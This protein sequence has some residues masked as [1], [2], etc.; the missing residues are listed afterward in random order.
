MSFGLFKRK[1]RAPAEHEWGGPLDL[2]PGDRVTYYQQELTLAGVVFLAE[3][4]N[5]HCQYH[6]LD[7]EERHVVIAFSSGPDPVISIEHP[8]PEEGHP[9]IEAEVFK[10]EDTTFKRG[11]ETA[12]TAFSF[13]GIPTEKGDE[14]KVTAYEDED[15]LA[16]LRVED[17]DG[18]VEVRAGDF[19]H[20]NE[21]V[22][23]R[24][25]DEDEWDIKPPPRIDLRSLNEARRAKQMARKKVVEEKKKSD[26]DAAREKLAAFEGE[27]EIPE[28]PE[29]VV[30]LSDIVDPSYRFT[31][32]ARLETSAAPEPAESR[33]SLEDLDAPIPAPTPSGS[34]PAFPFEDDG[35]D[36]FEQE[37]GA[38]ETFDPAP[39]PYMEYVENEREEEFAEVFTDVGLPPLEP[40][41]LNSQ[42]DSV[43][44][45]LTEESTDE[46]INAGVEE[47]DEFDQ[48]P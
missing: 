40:N 9:S 33:E 32:E 43:K 17:W 48:E 41:P 10:H 44:N 23:H 26:L 42:K 16:V 46:F 13:G 29:D 4:K 21:L 14:V 38:D 5:R 15:E 36:P 8:I 7:Q 19:I 18:Y 28:D 20:E 12:F 34:G 47:E 25:R 22:L 35:G 1:P 2:V 6:F 3:A 11:E 37:F 27:E 24:Q 39:D 45:F 30:A 31:D